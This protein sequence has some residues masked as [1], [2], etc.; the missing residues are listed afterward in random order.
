VF[1]FLSIADICIFRSSDT[2]GLI[3][4]PA[5]HFASLA[6]QDYVST[7]DIDGINLAG[8]NHGRGLVS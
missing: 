3:P 7:G 2:L 4:D 1:F 6:K 5:P 8:A